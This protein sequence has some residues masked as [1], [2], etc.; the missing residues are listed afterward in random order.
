MGDGDVAAMTA[1]CDDPEIARF[2]TIPSPYGSRH[3]RECLTQ[4]RRGLESGTDLHTVVVAEG[5]GE[6]AKACCAR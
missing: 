1:A 6:P 3:A 4:A 2:T 5:S